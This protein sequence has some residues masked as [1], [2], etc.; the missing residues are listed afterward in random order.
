MSGDISVAEDVCQHDVCGSRGIG[1]SSRA[2][3]SRSKGFLDKSDPDHPACERTIAA[4][5]MIEA[6]RRITAC[7]HCHD[8]LPGRWGKTGRG[9]QRWRCG[10]CQRSFSAA[11][12]T[13]FLGVHDVE[14]FVALLD[15]MMGDEP[16]S[17][18][19]LAKALL[20]DKDTIWRWR[21][22]VAR[23]LAE[24]AGPAPEQP[25]AEGHIVMRESRKA[26]REWVRHAREPMRFPA[27]DRRR[28]IDYRLM[29]LPL[30]MPM[31]PHLVTVT[32][33][34][35]DSGSAWAAISNGETQVERHGP[36]PDV[37][38]TTMRSETAPNLD[39]AVGEHRDPTVWSSHDRDE[40]LAVQNAARTSDDSRDLAGRAADGLCSALAVTRSTETARQ[41]HDGA[42]S[43]GVTL[44]VAF[45]AFIAPFRGP[46]TRYLDGYVA[47]FLA[48]LPT[49][50]EDRL[51]RLLAR[52]VGAGATRFGDMR[53]A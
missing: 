32:L 52:L 23:A 43:P 31:T 22:K 40:Q 14:K 46:A 39:F 11:T 16:R 17:C 42:T 20:V 38:A 50:L 1:G 18:R 45:S 4:L 15:D 30:P 35:D 10:S 53:A 37:P 5:A 24:Q 51:A 33:S 26:S 6:H 8:S 36:R 3:C 41:S 13:V 34:V 27:P 9:R 2:Q 29:R 12:S 25:K 47:W 49:T 21:R 44:P 19:A 28:W 7:P 48:R